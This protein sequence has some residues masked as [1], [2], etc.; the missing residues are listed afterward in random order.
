MRDGYNRVGARYNRFGEARFPL[1]LSKY[2]WLLREGAKTPFKKYKKN[3][4]GEKI[5][6]TFDL[7]DKYKVRNNKGEI[8]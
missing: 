6:F 3:E 2:S 4:P 1:G 7:P 8:K 5:A